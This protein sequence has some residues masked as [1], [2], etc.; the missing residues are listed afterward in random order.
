M[1]EGRMVLK[2]PCQPKYGAQAS[3]LIFAAI[4]NSS[5]EAVIG[6]G[7]REITST[8]HNTE[9]TSLQRFRNDESVAV[10]GFDNFFE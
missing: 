2:K 6:D 3:H 5:G 1:S 7:R 10:N 9:S 4:R 8:M